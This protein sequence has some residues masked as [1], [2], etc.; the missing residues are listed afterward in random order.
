[1]RVSRPREAGGATARGAG[2]DVPGRAGAAV[3]RRTPC[4]APV[5]DAVSGRCGRWKAT[6]RVTSSPSSPP[7]LSV[8]STTFR[9]CPRDFRPGSEITVTP[10][11]D[12]HHV[13][14]QLRLVDPPEAPPAPAS[15]ARKPS[16]SAAAHRSGTRTSGTRTSGSRRG[17][18]PRPAGRRAVRWGDWQLDART[19]TVGRQGVAAAREALERVAAEQER[20]RSGSR[21]PGS[22]RLAS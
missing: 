10:P 22:Q 8:T 7:V 2:A 9:G 16:R 5:S 21:T 1:M 17:P 20:A 19:R 6:T 11:G 3:A 14:T 18:G 15:R 13:T 12:D 4:A